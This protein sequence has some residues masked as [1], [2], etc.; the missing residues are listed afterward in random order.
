MKADA[1]L[2]SNTSGLDID[3]M[4]QLQNVRIRYVE[5]ISLAQPML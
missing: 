4:P 1:I 5:C 3:A 2:A